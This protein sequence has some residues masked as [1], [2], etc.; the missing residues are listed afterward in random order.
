MQNDIETVD[1]FGWSVN[2]WSA[3]ADVS[4]SST[5]ELIA[6]NKIKSVKFGGKRI[7]LTHPR[8]FLE[9]LAGAA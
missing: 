3:A 1:K 6:D 4:R 7:I 9:S 8:E 5:Y 2:N